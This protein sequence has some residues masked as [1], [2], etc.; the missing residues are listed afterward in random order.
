MIGEKIQVNAEVLENEISNL[1]NLLNDI[2]SSN[3]EHVEVE[4]AGYTKLY[5][6]L[7]GKAFSGVI[8]SLQ[9]LITSTVNMLNE[10]KDG[11]IE[12]DENTRDFIEEFKEEVLD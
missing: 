3:I 7:T 9:L 11:Y 4:G 6:D 8:K 2:D 10:I 5:M 12:I 1:K